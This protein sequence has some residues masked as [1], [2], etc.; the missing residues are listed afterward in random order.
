MLSILQ[1]KLRQGKMMMV[2][3]MGSELGERKW[4]WWQCR[5]WSLERE[6]WW[7][8]R[9]G[10]GAEME[11]RVD[12]EKWRFAHLRRRNR[13]SLMCSSCKGFHL[14]KSIE[15]FV[16]QSF[17][18]YNKILHSRVSKAF[19]EENIFKQTLSFKKV[20]IWSYKEL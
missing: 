20:W 10:T 16:L 19:G 9:A 3:V 17:W 12:L 11:L 14:H 2:T 18:P 4:W 5:G 15:D 8:N 6:Q 13:E 1:M 7:W